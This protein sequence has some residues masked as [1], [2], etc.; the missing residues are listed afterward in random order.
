MIQEN[1]LVLGERYHLTATLPLL[2][3]LDGK[4][5]EVKCADAAND[6]RTH[7][8]TLLHYSNSDPEASR[9]AGCVFQTRSLYRF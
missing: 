1:H 3:V 7:P 4:S 5:G 2:V 9:R 8:L 6:I